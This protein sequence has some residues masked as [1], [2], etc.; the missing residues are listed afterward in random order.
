MVSLE[1][2]SRVFICESDIRKIIASFLEK[3]GYNQIGELEIIVSK[4]KIPEGA[5]QGDVIGINA[6]VEPLKFK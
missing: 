2:T 4:K 5:T 1:E 6:T 3:E